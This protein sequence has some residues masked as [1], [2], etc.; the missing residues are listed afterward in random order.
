MS[1]AAALLLDA[2]VGDPP[3]LW[4]RVPH[5]VVWAG[6]FIDWFDTNF[7][8]RRRA[9]GILL[10]I[11]LA[12]VAGLAGWF[13]ERL[14]GGAVLSPLIAAILLA[15]RSLQEHVRAVATGLDTGLAEGRRAVAR[16]VGRDVEVLDEPAVVRAA[17]ESAAE[18]FS[19]GLVAPAFWYALL[20]LPG[21][22]VYKAVNTADSMVGHRN[23][24]HG[25]FGWAAARLDDSLNLL[26]ARLSAILIAGPSIG[27]MRVALRDAHMHR[28]PNA[29]WPEAAMAARLDLA[30]AG[31]RQYAGKRSNDPFVFGEGRRN[32]T[33]D[34]IRRCC[35][36]LRE[37]F[38]WLLIA[39]V[40]VDLV[41][42]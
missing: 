3:L 37:A 27:A 14:P 20:G 19:D 30:L 6:R 38:V 2:I 21:I 4:R 23:E 25:R 11:L 36:I 5:P 7:N 12:V 22:L 34:D 35:R 16:I 40:I 26:P 10:V 33:A 13:V 1:I 41:R 15:G 17:V 8:R 29:G 42:S 39:A 31:P 18:N 24:R 28:S 32:G 9:E